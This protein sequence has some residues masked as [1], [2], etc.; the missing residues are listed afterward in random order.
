MAPR[1]EAHALGFSKVSAVDVVGSRFV[2]LSLVGVVAA[3]AL[4]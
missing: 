4:G 1:D 3:G 2:A